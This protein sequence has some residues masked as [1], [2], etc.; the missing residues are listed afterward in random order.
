MIFRLKNDTTLKV[1][2]CNSKLRECNLLAVAFIQSFHVSKVEVRYEHICCPVT[3]I[4]VITLSILVFVFLQ[5]LH[6]IKELNFIVVPPLV[7]CA[8]YLF[9][10][11]NSCIAF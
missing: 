10:N 3:H 11:D 4:S 8:G 9:T 7:L 6:Q 1:L 5:Y 2:K